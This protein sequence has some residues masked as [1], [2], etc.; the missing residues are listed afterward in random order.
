LKRERERKREREEQQTGKKILIKTIIFLKKNH[1][2]VAN[3]YEKLTEF[4]LYEIP[5]SS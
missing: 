5:Y 1:F 4:E 2:G 3:T